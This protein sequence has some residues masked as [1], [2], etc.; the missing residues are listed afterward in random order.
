MSDYPLAMAYLQKRIS[1]DFSVEMMNAGVAHKA[2]ALPYM[3]SIS[4]EDLLTEGKV[5]DHF[6]CEQRIL[7]ER[8]KMIITR[9][10]NMSIFASLPKTASVEFWE[11]CE[12]LCDLT[13]IVHKEQDTVVIEVGGKEIRIYS[14]RMSNTTMSKVEASFMRG[15]AMRHIRAVGI[16]NRMDARIKI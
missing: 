16:K 7:D 13:P 10:Y 2:Y 14:N 11:I 6:G 4:T 5:L 1:S 3:F 15:L 8:A 9:S 12:A